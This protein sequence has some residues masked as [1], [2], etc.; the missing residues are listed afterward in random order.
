MKCTL[1]QLPTHLIAVQH[2]PWRDTSPSCSLNELR[3][4]DTSFRVNLEDAG[5]EIS[6]HSNSPNAETILQYKV[7]PLTPRRTA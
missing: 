3:F 2:S 4:K 7:R 6:V 5:V 1:K